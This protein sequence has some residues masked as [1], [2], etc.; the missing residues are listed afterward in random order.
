MVQASRERPEPKGL[1]RL[2]EHA[3][4]RSASYTGVAEH[5]SA[6]RQ[7]FFGCGAQR[8][9]IGQGLGGVERNQT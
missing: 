6:A 1:P 5:R 9:Y 4:R 2:G 3:G 7:I 8:W